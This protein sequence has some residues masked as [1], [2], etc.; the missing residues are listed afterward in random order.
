M[1]ADE[2]E[3]APMYPTVDRKDLFLVGMDFRTASIELRENTNLA[4]DETRARALRK[5]K[6]GEGDLEAVALF[7]CNRNE[8]YAAASSP[9]AVETWLDSLPAR[10]GGPILNRD[11]R[12]VYRM[13][14]AE[15]ARHLF[16]VASGLESSILGDGQ[17]LGQVRRAVALS[18]KSGILGRHLQKTFAFALRCGAL[19]H[20]Q[21]DIGRGAAGVGSALAAILAS[22]LPSDSSHE[23]P[24]ILVLGAGEVARDTAAQLAKRRVG[25]LVF[26]NRTAAKSE[27]LAREMRGRS[28]PWSALEVSLARANVVIAATSSPTPVLTRCILERSALDRNGAPLLVVDLGMPRNVEP[29]SDGEVIDIDAVQ[30]RGEA[31]LARR[32]LAIPRVEQIVEDTLVA[33]AR[34]SALQSAEARI[35]SLYRAASE[36]SKQAG[37]E[38][39]GLGEVDSRSVER[40]VFRSIKRLLHEHVRDLRELDSNGSAEHAGAE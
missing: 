13:R 22:R 40:V 11:V 34:F 31:A 38:I 20:Q 33:W 5:V 26:A 30:E 14:G 29:G 17:I 2:E 18:A 10:H 12:H 7:T 32:R 15:A 35:K 36:I 8:I 37:S 4:F 28:V 23:P 27:A 6:E 3:Q 39:V 1:P 9:H 24:E 21:T 19:A 16:R 25:R